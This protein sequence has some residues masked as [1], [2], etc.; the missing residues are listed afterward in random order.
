MK[1]LDNLSEWIKKEVERLQSFYDWDDVSGRHGIR[2]STS[3]KTL[4]GIQK[5]IDELKN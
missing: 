2:L 3:I 1:I 4:Q 5:K